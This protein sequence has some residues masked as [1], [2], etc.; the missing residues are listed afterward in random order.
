MWANCCAE[1]RDEA[2]N[3]ASAFAVIDP[4]RQK[5]SLF[6]RA[7]WLDDPLPGAD[8]IDYL[9]IDPTSKFT[10]YLAGIEWYLHPQLRFSPNI[11]VVN[12]RRDID[13][14]VVPRIT[15]YWTW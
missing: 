6:A 3:I 15:F 5:L 8:G 2:D 12:Y 7:D 10:Y 1:V 14:D 13:T 9:P 11:E 4:I